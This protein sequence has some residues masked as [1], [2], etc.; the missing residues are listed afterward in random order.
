[1]DQQRVWSCDYREIITEEGK[2]DLADVKAH[3]E[4]YLNWV[5]PKEKTAMERRMDELEAEK[6]LLTAQVKALSDRNDF[7]EDC[8]AEMAGVVY[9]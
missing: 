3:P 8:L 9:S 6:R 5:E 2:I 1:M 7:V 4:N